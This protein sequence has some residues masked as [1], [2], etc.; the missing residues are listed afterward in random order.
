MI[1]IVLAQLSLFMCCF[2][3]YKDA[4]FK[5]EYNSLQIHDEETP[6]I[7]EDEIEGAFLP[8]PVSNSLPVPPPYP[9]PSPNKYTL[10]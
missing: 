4:V 3:S 9:P 5:M 1:I 8:S 6:L 10:A 7:S 2:I